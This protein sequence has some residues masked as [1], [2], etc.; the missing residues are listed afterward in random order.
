M[1]PDPTIVWRPFPTF[2]DGIA[3]P[4]VLNRGIWRGVLGLLVVGGDTSGGAFGVQVSCQAYFAFERALY[5]TAAGVYDG[6]VYL[7]EADSSQLL[8]A[9]DS[10]TSS[11]AK[12]RHFSFVG[13]D[14]C[15]ETVGF[16][17]PVIRAFESREEA[18]DWSPGWNEF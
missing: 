9:F 5:S 12:P 4:L 15:Y 3:E 1:F 6:G 7:K 2:M 14:F 8:S 16:R 10:A 17:A 13:A 18:Y 11:R